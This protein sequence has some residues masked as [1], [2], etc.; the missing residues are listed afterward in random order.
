[1]SLPINSIPA[2]TAGLAFREHSIPIL[3]DAKIYAKEY[4]G[5]GPALYLMHGFPDNFH[6]YDYLLPFVR[7]HFKI[8]TF[9]F[10]GWNQSDKPKEY[11]YTAADQLNQLKKVIAYFGDT[12]VWLVAHDAS[13]PP[14]INFA[15][16][17]PERVSK[18]IL[19]NTYYSPMKELRTPEAIKMFSTPFISFFTG[20]V[21][22]HFP[23]I[24]KKVYYK[25]IKR[26]IINEERKKELVP[27]LYKSFSDKRNFQA[28][29]KLN[30]D[31]LS[32]IEENGKR[33]VEFDKLKNKCVIIFGD[34]D[35]YLN[36][37]VAQRFHELIPGSLKYLIPDAGHY[38][39]VDQ[40]EKLAQ[41]MISSKSFKG[42][43]YLLNK[44]IYCFYLLIDLS[45]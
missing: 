39:Q 32:C 38:V 29:L 20:F 18:L 8:I 22:S 37:K 12:E 44:L 3:P 5:E 23:E 2:T 6:L 24:N 42:N 26:F 25:Q 21:A 27:L 1:M 10:L 17:Y 28:F 36:K 9:D 45:L 19:L 35:P 7:G 30:A 11:G 31:L 15:L 34:D 41:L 14:V 40:P 4:M 43:D 33:L 16:N 13:G